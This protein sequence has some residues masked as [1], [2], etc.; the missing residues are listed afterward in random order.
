MAYR[1]LK[2]DTTL[3]KIT[4]EDDENEELKDRTEKHDHE[5]ILKS[6]H[7]DDEYYEKK[8]RNFKKEGTFNYQ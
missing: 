5:K 6:L 7:I 1:I 3:L 2:V 4:T 8:D